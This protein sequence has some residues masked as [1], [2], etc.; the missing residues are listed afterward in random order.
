M[1][2]T[3]WPL[4]DEDEGGGLDAGADATAVVGTTAAELVVG[5]DEVVPAVVVLCFWNNSLP[6]GAV[7]LADPENIDVCDEADGE[8]ADGPSQ[9]GGSS[10]PGAHDRVSLKMP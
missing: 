6:A 9:S 8:M 7:E 5:V 3:G 1:P 4:L 2:D 10:V